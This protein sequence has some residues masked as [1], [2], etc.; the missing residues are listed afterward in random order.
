MK[1]HSF[2]AFTFVEMLIVIVI[3]GILIAALLPIL[4]GNQGIF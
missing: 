1:Q 3:I 2:K 4:Q